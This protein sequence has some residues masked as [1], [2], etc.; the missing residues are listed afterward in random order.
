MNDWFYPWLPGQKD[1]GK[2]LAYTSMIWVH[3]AALLTCVGYGVYHLAFALHFVGAASIGAGLCVVGAIFSLKRG[4]WN[5]ALYLGFFVCQLVAISITSYHYGIRGM[6]LAFPLIT[7][8][9]YILPYKLAMLVAII[10]SFTM[11]S[12]SQAHLTTEEGYG[13]AIALILS[14]VM[15]AAFSRLMTHR[16]EELIEDASIDYLTGIFNRRGFTEKA[17]AFLQD[18]KHKKQEAYLFAFDLDNFKAINDQYGHHI[19][20]LALQIFTQNISL[21]LKRC[22]RSLNSTAFNIFG[23]RSGD[24]FELLISGLAEAEFESVQRSLLEAKSTE[25]LIGGHEIILSATMGLARASHCAWAL[26]RMEKSADTSM[27]DAK[28]NKN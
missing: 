8:A 23:R 28:N 13:V 16:A 14:V 20:D 25:H 19:G 7:S 17:S 18:A 21:T 5:N 15:A 12:A 22:M 3:Y 11:W 27:Y 1:S 10:K 2:S 9:F 6:V 26:D 24:E 4:H